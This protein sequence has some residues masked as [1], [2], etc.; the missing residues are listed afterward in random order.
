MRVIR[1]E[2]GWDIA[3]DMV[4]TDKQTAAIVSERIRHAVRVLVCSAVDPSMCSQES[5]SAKNVGGEAL[6]GNGRAPIAQCLGHRLHKEECSA[7]T[8]VPDA[9]SL[10]R[11]RYCS[12]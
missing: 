4:F 11:K 6:S 12:D 9:L 7:K 2:S 1:H 3:L 8:G 10:A 5:G